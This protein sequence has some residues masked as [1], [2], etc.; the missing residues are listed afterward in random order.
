M[1]IETSW[2]PSPENKELVSEFQKKKLERF[3]ARL[4]W[5]IK[6]EERK[7]DCDDEFVSYLSSVI[8]RLQDDLFVVGGHG[9][10]KDDD[11]DRII[12]T[13]DPLSQEHRENISAGV[14]H[15]LKEKSAVEKG[16]RAEFEQEK[17]QA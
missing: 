4:E 9:K 8:M 5:I 17:N 10:P 14:K 15:A 1:T 6:D 2:R 12:W 3:R 11:S 13:R 16:M 7:S